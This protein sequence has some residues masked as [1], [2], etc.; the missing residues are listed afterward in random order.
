MAGFV[1]QSDA[2]GETKLGNFGNNS[3]SANSVADSIELAL[4]RAAKWT[5]ADCA[6][7]MEYK[8]EATVLRL[9]NR[10]LLLGSSGIKSRVFSLGRST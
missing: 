10:V 8:R 2:I 5:A 1:W 3:K 7:R 9:V 4:K 6:P